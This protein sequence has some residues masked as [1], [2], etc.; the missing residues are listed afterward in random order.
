[1]GNNS[2]RDKFIPH[3]EPIE[4]HP[5]QLRPNQAMYTLAATLFKRDPA[6]WKIQDIKT[7]FSSDGVAVL[8]SAFVDHAAT[9]LCTEMTA[10]QQLRLAHQVTVTAPE[11]ILEFFQDSRKPEGSDLH[12]LGFGHGYKKP[13]CAGAIALP[14]DHLKTYRE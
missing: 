2:G 4:A 3:K 5:Q 11:T 8:N 9:T 13:T 6:E 12:F 14:N 10:S 1:V 7:P